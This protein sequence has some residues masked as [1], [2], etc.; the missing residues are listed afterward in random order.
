VRE[1]EER[2]APSQGRETASCSAC[3]TE[4]S[5][6]EAI[7]CRGQDFS[8]LHQDMVNT[9]SSD[10]HK[11]RSMGP[12][13]N[14]VD[15]KTPLS[16]KRTKSNG[17]NAVLSPSC[18][19][20]VAGLA[21]QPPEMTLTHKVPKSNNSP[22]G[23]GNKS[24]SNEETTPPPPPPPPMP[25]SPSK[26][27]RRASGDTARHH[28]VPAVGEKLPHQCW[29]K[30]L[31]SLEQRRL[32]DRLKDIQLDD[33]IDYHGGVLNARFVEQ[34]IGLYDLLA[35]QGD[36]DKPSDNIYAET[37]LG[38]ELPYWC[39]KEDDSGFTRTERLEMAAEYDVWQW[40]TI[41]GENYSLLDTLLWMGIQ[42]KKLWSRPVSPA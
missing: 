23:D 34:I 14:V 18:V 6:T 28:S 25:D 16:P 20:A 33:M 22:K 39:P 13:P 12:A 19:A 8:I 5:F 40:Y 9:R 2:N 3:S 41:T 21:L 35:A 42:M 11:T 15:V 4:A 1:I 31:H 26:G 38:V 36:D 29:W 10:A 27:Q 17:G 24:P 32:V 37:A 30:Q 7:P